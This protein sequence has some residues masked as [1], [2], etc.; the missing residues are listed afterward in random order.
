M[1]TNTLTQFA[2]ELQHWLHQT[3]AALP[4]S[5]QK[6]LQ[7][8]IHRTTTAKGWLWAGLGF[9]LLWVWIWQWVLSIAVGLSVMVGVYLAQQGRFKLSWRGWQKLWHRSNRATTLAAM[10]G[11]LALG[12]TYLAT[13]V[14]IESDQ[15]WLATSIVLEG[16]G[17]LAIFGLLVWQMLNRQFQQQDQ[18]NEQFQKL[19]ANLSHAD[20][21]KRLIAVRQLTQAVLNPVASQAGVLMAP[22]HLA[23]CFR[24]MLDRETEPLVCSA[25]MESLQRL[26]PTRQLAASRLSPMSARPVGKA[27]HLRFSE[28][29]GEA[30]YG[31]E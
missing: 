30:D 9:L 12:S 13:A 6:Q 1:K 28:D 23:E 3:E 8:L 15:H 22:E 14:W 24:L 11:L 27:P 5:L 25:L 7:R 10:A 31:E 2:S 17:I 19:L 18:G 20:P 21:L 29:Y 16:F 4:V 26:N